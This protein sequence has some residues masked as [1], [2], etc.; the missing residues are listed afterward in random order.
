MNFLTRSMLALAVLV[1]TALGA[2]TLRRRT[3]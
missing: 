2:A 1:A 3:N